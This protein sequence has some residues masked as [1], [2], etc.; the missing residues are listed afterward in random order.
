MDKKI[1][2]NIKDAWGSYDKQIKLATRDLKWKAKL[3]EKLY[4][5]RENVTRHLMTSS[6]TKRPM[7]HHRSVSMTVASP[8]EKNL[9]ELTPI[10]QNLD[11]S[12]CEKPKMP[13]LNLVQDQQKGIS[14]L[15]EQ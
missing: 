4:F 7:I 12:I 13:L 6:G 10:P 8:H 2:N 11:M 5:E 1:L 9:P 15:Q 3:L 14:K